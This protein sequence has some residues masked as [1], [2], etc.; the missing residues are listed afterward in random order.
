MSAIIIAT[1][2]KLIIARSSSTSKI[3]KLAC[4]TVQIPQNPR[5]L[6]H[7]VLFCLSSTGDSCDSNASKQAPKLIIMHSFSFQF[8]DV[9]WIF[10]PFSLQIFQYGDSKATIR[11]D[12]C[13]G[14]NSPGARIHDCR[15][16][17]LSNLH[18]FQTR[19]FRAQC[20]T[21]TRH[22]TY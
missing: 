2:A 5:L 7:H 9:V 11:Y 17:V 10:A 22:E 16:L 6:R 8:C 18:R 4:K 21:R 14:R 15:A 20:H 13:S 19:S 12:I 3:R 1:S